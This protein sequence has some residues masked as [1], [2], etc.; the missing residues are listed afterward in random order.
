MRGQAVQKGTLDYKSKSGVNR[1]NRR[2]SLDLWPPKQRS[3]LAQD[4]KQIR[5]IV[6]LEGA[7]SDRPARW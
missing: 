7:Y 1:R 2:S 3:N 4:C 5:Q 6:T